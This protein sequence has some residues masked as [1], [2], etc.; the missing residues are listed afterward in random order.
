MI[1]AVDT[2]IILDLL[3]RNSPH[4]FESRVALATANRQGALV[5]SE[6]VVSELAGR[7]LEVTQ[8]R[9]FLI[10]TRLR[11]EPSHLDALH[12]A[13]VAWRE[14]TRRR[15]AQTACPTC[16]TQ[17]SLSCTNCGRSLAGRQHVLAD[18]LIGAHALRHADLL[19]T[20]DRGFYGTYFPELRLA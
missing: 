10:D 1:T 13:G 14:Y 2:N 16:G 7:F 15:G 17:H 4:S 11:M 9:D 6:P 5:V 3:I 20:R 8:L 12:R 19:L 18:F